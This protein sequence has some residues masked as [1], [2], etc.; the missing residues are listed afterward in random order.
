MLTLGA[1][2]WIAPLSSLVLPARAAEPAGKV[3]VAVV[4]ME[5][6]MNEAKPVAAL[7]AEF[8]STLSAQ[9]KQL[10]NLYAGRL[11]DDKERAELETLQ[12]LAS[13]NG[14]QT[15]RIAELSK[16]SDER[17]TE[18]ERLTRLQNPSDADRNRRTQLQ[19]NLERQNQRV[20]QLQQSL[21]QAR[22]QKQQE[23]MQRAMQTVLAAVR[24]IAQERGIE[25]VV[26]QNSVLFSRDDRDITDEVLQ[27]LNG[28]A[29]AKPAPK[30]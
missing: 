8:K 28:T 30:K 11:L 5:R 22:Q 6:V 29:A 4:S 21:G 19:N 18:L 27:R 24:G 14:T 23:V 3:A 10:D 15:K 7:D 9:Q 12:K 2:L 1:A 20:M 26:D 16:V 13:P 25:M 17:Q